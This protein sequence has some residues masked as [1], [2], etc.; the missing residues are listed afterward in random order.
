MLTFS[1]ATD[2]FFFFFFCSHQSRRAVFNSSLCFVRKVLPMVDLQSDEEVTLVNKALSLFLKCVGFFDELNDSFI[3]EAIK[4]VRLVLKEKMAVAFK[5][6][7]TFTVTNTW[8][9]KTSEIVVI[10]Q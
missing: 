1:Y 7:F 3:A 2:F 4:A 5:N 6:P 10:L 9:F 8:L